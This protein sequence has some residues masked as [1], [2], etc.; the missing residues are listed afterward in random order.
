MRIV[1]EITED[2]VSRV[3][4]IVDRQ[5][6][7]PL[8]LDR[9]RRNL[10]AAKPAITKLRFWQEL[11]SCLLTTQQRSGPS[12]PVT[13]FICTRPFPLSYTACLDQPDIREFTSQTISQ[14]GGIR[15]AVTLGDQIGENLDNLEAGLWQS[16]LSQMERLSDSPSREIEVEVADFVDDEFRGFGPKQA[17]N[18]L[19]GLGLTRYEI[20]IDSRVSK[21]L[22]QIGFPV[23][24][25]PA[26]LSDARY[27]HFISTAVVELCQ[28]SGVYPC[29]LDAAVFSSFDSEAW[30]D[31]T[32]GG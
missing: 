29:V 30:T 6:D 21:W 1:W 26:A 9:I 11:V 28:R 16:T 24:L 14:F 7:S 4:S 8:V 32:V 2:D 31:E 15:R 12:S 18:L 3:K 20:P 5:K 23:A 27:Y 19:Q 13:R 17:R 25:S 22:M 10:A